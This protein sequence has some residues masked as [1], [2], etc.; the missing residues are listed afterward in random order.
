MEWYG[1]AGDKWAFWGPGERGGFRTVT[2]WCL[3]GVG[4]MFHSVG[5]ESEIFLVFCTEKMVM[6]HAY[7]LFDNGHD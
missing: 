2:F 1:I 5:L 4:G 7:V 3:A 6:A